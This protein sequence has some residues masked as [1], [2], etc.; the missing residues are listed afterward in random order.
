MMDSQENPYD[1]D[2]MPRDIDT[3]GND[4][5]DVD[6]DVRDYDDDGVDA[7]ELTDPSMP[8]LPPLPADDVD[9]NVDVNDDDDDGIDVDVDGVDVEDDEDDDDDDDDDDNNDDSPSHYPQS[10]GPATTTATTTTTSKKRAAASVVARVYKSTIHFR[11]DLTKSARDVHPCGILH[12]ARVVGR[13]GGGVGPSPPPLSSSLTS[14]SYH[15]HRA[16]EHAFVWITRYHDEVCLSSALLHMSKFGFDRS[17]DDG[18]DGDNNY[19]IGNGNGN[20]NGKGNGSSSVVFVPYSNRRSWIIR[21]PLA[22][23]HVYCGDGGVVTGFPFWS[24]GYGCDVGIAGGGGGG[25]VAAGTMMTMTTIAARTGGRAQP[26]GETAAN[27]VPASSEDAATTVTM[28][29][30]A[31]DGGAGGP[32]AGPGRRRMRK[33][34]PAANLTNDERDEL[35]VEIYRYFRWLRDS[36]SLSTSSSA[37]SHAASDGGGGVGIGGTATISDGTD[38]AFADRIDGSGDTVVSVGGA[39]GGMAGG[40]G[41]KRSSSNVGGGYA[42]GGI[43]LSSLDDLVE[44]MKSAFKVV[45][46]DHQANGG[47]WPNPSQHSSYSSIASDG[48]PFLEESLGEP[49]GRLAAMSRRDQTDGRRGGGDPSSRGDGYNGRSGGLDFDDMYGRLVRFRQVRVL[50]RHRIRFLLFDINSR[51]PLPLHTPHALRNHRSTATSM[52]PRSTPRTDS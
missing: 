2:G 7:A 10:G 24:V 6:V 50:M 33:I 23:P 36:L 25:A 27:D 28:A 43:K 39:G 16:E 20:G 31:T 21:Y 1:Y 34:F 45:R 13:S 52:C 42:A 14:L 12:F 32:A 4:D 15:R 22:F 37:S 8:V 26:T 11:T 35:H 5:V 18:D 17:K 9:V 30:A 49:L 47:A 51:P 19:V 29:T 48:M 41:N 44:G 46:G 38:D 40:D 3:D